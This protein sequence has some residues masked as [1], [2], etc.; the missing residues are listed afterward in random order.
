M[1]KIYWELERVKTYRVLIGEDDWAKTGFEQKL[2]RLDALHATVV[3]ECEAL[4][5][6]MKEHYEALQKEREARYESHI[7]VRNG[8]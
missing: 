1:D 3:D 7:Q 5:N 4:V 8:E 2:K 6:E